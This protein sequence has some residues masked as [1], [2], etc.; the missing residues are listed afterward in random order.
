MNFYNQLEVIFFLCYIKFEIITQKNVF[1]STTI[2]QFFIG[3]II[4]KFLRIFSF[5]FTF[6]ILINSSHLTCVAL[7]NNGEWLCETETQL[8]GEKIFYE[9]Y[10]DGNIKR[11]IEYDQN[12]LIT[13]IKTYEYDLM[14]NITKYTYTSNDETYVR[15]YEYL[16]DDNGNIIN[17]T[18]Y[19]NEEF[20]YGFIYEYNS[21]NLLL[22]EIN[23]SNNELKNKYTYDS[24]NNLIKEE[25]FYQGKLSTYKT[26]VYSNNILSTEEY[27]NASGSK[28]YRKSYTSTG[29]IDAYNDYD[30]DSKT[31]YK[32]NS[33][34][35][36]SELIYYQFGRFIRRT[37]Y[38][39]DSDTGK[40]RSIV[41]YDSND[42]K[43]GSTNYKYD[44]RGNLISVISSSSSGKTTNSTQYTYVLVGHYEHINTIEF[45]EL[46]ATC[47][48]AG[49]TAGTYCL[50][51]E[52]YIS[53]HTEIDIDTEN[54]KWDNGIITTIATCTIPG[55]KTYT[56]INDNSHKKI[57]TLG[58]N[59]S[60][61]VNTKFFTA[62]PPTIN[63]NGYTE[64]VYCY[65]CKN[66]IEGHEEIPKLTP[67]FNDSEN[68]KIDGCYIFC[69]YGLTVEQL[70]S[71]AN[72]GAYILTT[73]G[74]PANEIDFVCTGMILIMNETTEKEI[75]VY[76][77]I[78]GDGK[79]TA[80]DARLVLRISAKLE[81]ATDIQFKLADYNN[82]GKVTAADAR[83]VL[84]KSAKLD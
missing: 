26:Y 5:L 12:G 66:F 25:N 49:Y 34:D 79:I 27:F 2:L 75:I 46:I 77:D 24:D 3:E 7:S 47:T 74:L 68:A 38:S 4:M 31:F 20:Q 63:S 54:H 30:V 51:C 59:S 61:H 52:T 28:K 23:S 21:E 57:E 16:Y 42:K 48:D 11:T 8:S 43:A 64:G 76:G 44:S 6:I 67:Q 32:Y 18:A 17:K 33:K 14:A 71:Q 72:K 53:G 13:S 78:N 69:N 15:T 41:G 62:I 55:L 83:L 60:N 82:D 65:D 84:R 1:N 40:L 39:Y 45:E 35:K 80:A 29:K 19:E 36:L 22:K 50:D 56:C 73:D 10:S 37:T 58:I 70:L 9:Y 81:K